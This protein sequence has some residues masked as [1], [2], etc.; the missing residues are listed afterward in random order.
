MTASRPEMFGAAF[1]L[2]SS[3]NHQ[4]NL[5]PHTEHHELLMKLSVG[6]IL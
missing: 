2:F 1:L 3:Q 6:Y 5:L 4:P